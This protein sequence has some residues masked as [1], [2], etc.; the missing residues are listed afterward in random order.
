MFIN[1]YE[2][3]LKL[4]FAAIQKNQITS[5]TKEYDIIRLIRKPLFNSF[6][7]FTFKTRFNSLHFVDIKGI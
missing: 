7:Y 1:D 5:N 2:I 3:R 6:D 4:T